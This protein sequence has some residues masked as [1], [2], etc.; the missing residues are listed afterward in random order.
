[1]ICK[2]W[3]CKTFSDYFVKDEFVKYNFYLIYFYS[4]S[5]LIGSSKI[6]IGVFEKMLRILLSFTQH[7]FPLVNCVYF[8]RSEHFFTD[9]QHP[10]TR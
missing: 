3:I 7:Y 9:D 4:G 10:C 8:N 1:M 2:R 5:T 6:K